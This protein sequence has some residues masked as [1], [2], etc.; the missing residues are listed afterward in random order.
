MK[1]SLLTSI[2]TRFVV[3]KSDVTLACWQSHESGGVGQLPAVNS[4]V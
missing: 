1:H 3:H 2:K 4:P